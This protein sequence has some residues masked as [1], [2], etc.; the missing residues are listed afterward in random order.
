MKKIISVIATFAA[1]ITISS[2]ASAYDL[3]SYETETK[4]IKGESF[5]VSTLQLKLVD[6]KPYTG[7][8]KQKMERVTIM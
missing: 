2:S 7:F 6:G 4:I 5:G 1:A 3:P 8:T